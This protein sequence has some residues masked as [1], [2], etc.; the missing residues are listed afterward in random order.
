MVKVGASLSQYIATLVSTY[1]FRVPFFFQRNVKTKNNEQIPIVH[2][3]FRSQNLLLI[4]DRKENV[5]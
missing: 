1:H 3:L 2:A 4:D 5:R